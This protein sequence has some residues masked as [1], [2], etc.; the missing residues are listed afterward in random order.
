MGLA[1]L[2]LHRRS[3][4]GPRCLAGASPARRRPCTACTGG[5]A[6]RRCTCTSTGPM[7]F[8]L[9]GQ[10]LPWLPMPH[11]QQISAAPLVPLSRCQPFS[12]QQ[13]SAAQARPAHVHRPAHVYRPA[14]LITAHCPGQQL[15]QLWLV[16]QLALQRGARCAGGHC[17]RQAALVQMTQHAQRA[18][19]QLRV[20]P[21]AAS[22]QRRQMPVKVLVQRCCCYR[23]GCADLMQQGPQQHAASQRRYVGWQAV[24]AGAK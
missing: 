1:A 10:V 16:G 13:R 24:L 4:T 15:P 20:R 22:T 6:C 18:W 23:C 5:P 2:H 19:Q 9:T 21:S 8:H 11:M 17:K 7:L 12:N 3:S 14:H